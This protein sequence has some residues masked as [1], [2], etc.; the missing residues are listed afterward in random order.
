MGQIVMTVRAIDWS[1]GNV[2]HVH[3]MLDGGS[4]RIDWGDRHEA[5]LKTGMFTEQPELLYAYHVYPIGCKASGTCYDIII[6]SDE[7]NIVGINADSG[8]MNVD[9]IDIK[10]CQSIRY[11]SASHLISNFDLRTNPGI[12]TVELEGEACAIADF[13]NSKELRTLYYRYA[14]G[15]RKSLD[16]SKCDNLE[17]LECSYAY[18]EHIAISNRSALRNFVYDDLSP[19][20]AKSLEV[21]RRIVERNSGVIE[22]EDTE[23]HY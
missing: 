21:I 13:S 14:S 5:R 16:L 1:Q 20:K 23:I 4:C 17:C 15:G 18:L 10:E 19:L 11:F 22:Y 8:D 6:S 12:K 7:D 9:D 2:G 3:V